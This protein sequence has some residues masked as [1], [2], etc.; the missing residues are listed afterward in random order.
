MAPNL[1]WRDV[2][3]GARLASVL[4]E[5]AP[6]SVANDADL[7]ALAEH[8][9]GAAVGV[10]NFLFI[11]G[12]VGVVG[13]VIVDGRPLTGVAGYGGEVGHFP[14]NPTGHVCRCGSVG[15]WE[16]EV[17]EDALLARAGRRAGGGRGAVDDVL[18]D[19]A[20]G[21]PV[22]LAALDHIGQWL[23]VAL[24]GFVNLFNPECIV[25]GGV[26]GASYSFV[27]R[28]IEAELDRRA[29]PAA[30]ALV[31]VLPASLGAGASLVGAAELAFEVLLVDPAAW[32]GLRDSQAD[33]ASA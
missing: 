21:S 4:E 8:R 24:A 27:I 13:G 19:A 10:D 11:R 29:L 14:V 30:R 25:L 26:F 3:L 12:E 23:G 31:R 18:R 33:L 1:G 7:G 16:T 32:I 28:A 2:P 20:A 5:S 15:C 17:G 9:R 22:A 6:I